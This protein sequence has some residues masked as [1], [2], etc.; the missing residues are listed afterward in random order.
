MN[1]CR[2]PCDQPLMLHR[3]LRQS[4]FMQACKKY[5][6]RL[7]GKWNTDHPHSNSARWH[8]GK[9]CEDG[10]WAPEEG[11]V[12]WP[13][14]LDR[15]AI[16]TPPCQHSISLRDYRHDGRRHGLSEGSHSCPATCC[17]G[18]PSPWSSWWTTKRKR[19]VTVAWYSS[20]QLL[21][22]ASNRT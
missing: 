17:S 2:R 1:S 6:Q 13:E 8:G 3:V 20:L 12:E 7:G 10:S 9:A 14:R 16:H 11:H 5:C 15:D 21:K 4:R 18:V 19:R 22:M